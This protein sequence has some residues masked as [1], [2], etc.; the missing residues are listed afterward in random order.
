[1]IYRNFALCAL[2]LALVLPGLGCGGTP[3]ETRETTVEEYLD[4]WFLAAAGGSANL[5]LATATAITDTLIRRDPR[6]L[7]LFFN[8]LADDATDPVAKLLAMLCLMPYLDPDMTPLIVEMTQPG[9]ETTTRACAAHMLGVLDSRTAEARLRELLEDP[10]R[11]VRMA[12]ALVLLTRDDEEILAQVETFW[13]DPETTDPEREQMVLVLLGREH[14]EFL[15]IYEEAARIP[16]LSPAARERIIE[17]LGR[18]GQASSIAALDALA[19]E[20]A[21]SSIRDMARVTADALRAR[22]EDAPP[23]GA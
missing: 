10:E 3:P 15:G 5:D 14:A 18:H 7:Q 9:F 4:R 8:I 23:A 1:M 20:A 12:A 2:L 11:R 21:E 6:N 22:L 19:E 16:D 13:A 17:F